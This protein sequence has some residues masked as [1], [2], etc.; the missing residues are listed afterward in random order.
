MNNHEYQL[1]NQR[2]LLKPTLQITVFTVLG[3]LVSFVTQIIIATKFGATMERD[4]YFAAVVVPGYISA[5]L[6]GSLTLTFV[7]IFIEYETKKSKA[8]AWIVTSIFINIT[9]LRL[10]IYII[11]HFNYINII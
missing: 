1:N 4:A 8:E 5:V 3:V 6:L 7:P 9:F 10:F 11:S 2:G